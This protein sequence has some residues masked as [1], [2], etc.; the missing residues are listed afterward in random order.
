[1]MMVRHVLFGLGYTPDYVCYHE[2]VFTNKEY[3][4]SV[5]A[6]DGEWLAELGPMFF[7]IKAVDQC[8]CCCFFFFFFF[9]WIIFVNILFKMNKEKILLIFYFVLFCGL[10]RNHTKIV[11]SRSSVRKIKKIQWTGR[12]NR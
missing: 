4:R 5:T 8:C 1:M 3:M 12:W 2:L 7:S 6:V 9:T 11:S 10:S